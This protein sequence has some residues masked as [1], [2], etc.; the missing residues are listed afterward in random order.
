MSGIQLHLNTVL[1]RY[2]TCSKRSLHISIQFY[3]Y[4]SH[5][6]CI[7][8]TP[9]ANETTPTL[10]EMEEVGSNGAVWSG[11]REARKTLRKY[12]E[13]R[14]RKSSH[15]ILLG[16]RLL[17]NHSGS[18]GDESECALIRVTH[19]PCVKS[20]CPRMDGARAAVHCSA[21]LRGHGHCTGECTGMSL[22]YSPPWCVY[23]RRWRCFRGSL[24]TAVAGW[25]VCKA[26]VWRPRR[27]EFTPS[28]PH[29]HTHTHT[30][31]ESHT[32]TPSLALS[33]VRAGLMRPSSCM[34]RSWRPHPPTLLFVRGRW[35]FT[36][37]RAGVWMPSRSSPL[38][39]KCTSSQ[40]CD[41]AAIVPLD[42]PTLRTPSCY[43]SVLITAV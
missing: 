19:T 4:S 32:H 20:T 7:E 6:T 13:S 3:N 30:L 11:W 42:S 31:T 14:A 17:Q 26:C 40:L 23:R 37:P 10:L 1:E 24:V 34:S 21:R 35:R 41:L 36:R 25:C 18:L 12:R 5:T 29:T 27:S 15:V 8:T 2:T 38:S 43:L 22:L 28:H 33:C 39:L 16:T 9:Q